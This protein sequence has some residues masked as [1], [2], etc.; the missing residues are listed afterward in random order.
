MNIFEP[1]RTYPS[2]SRTAVVFIEATS[3]PASG[4]VRANEH[5]TGSAAARPR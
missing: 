4:S 5:S 3:E 1:F 2:P